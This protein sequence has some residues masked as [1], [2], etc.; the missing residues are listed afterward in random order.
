MFILQA[1]IGTGTWL[2]CNS[3]PG[4]QRKAFWEIR[5]NRGDVGCSNQTEKDRAWKCLKEH[6]NTGTR[7][8]GNTGTREHANI[9][10][11]PK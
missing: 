8:H 4:A 6:G 1:V 2:Q 9:E 11:F 5:D 3:H 10:D 7:E